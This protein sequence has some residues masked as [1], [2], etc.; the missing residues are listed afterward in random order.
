MARREAGKSGKGKAKVVAS[1]GRKAKSGDSKKPA[2]ADGK[3]RE[4]PNF[5]PPSNAETEQFTI[6]AEQAKKQNARIKTAQEELS[7]EKGKLSAIYDGA[8]E[9]GMQASR[10]RVLKK[11]LKEELR[12]QGERLAEAREMAWQAKTLNSPMVQLGLFD[13]LLKEPSI[14]EY[15][16]M[17]QHAG[18]NGESVDNLPG[19]PGSPEHTAALEGWKI[20]QKENAD[21]LVEQMGQQPAA[22]DVET[23]H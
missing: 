18:R 1:S 14:D 23:R 16:L 22:A 21:S 13:G 4:L 2:K 6:I 3:A 19:K 9:S 10:L 15:R 5:R 17:G 12:D 8:K 20:G 7:R 11:T